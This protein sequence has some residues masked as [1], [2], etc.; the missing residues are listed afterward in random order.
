MGVMFTLSDNEFPL[1]KMLHL[2]TK[3]LVAMRNA[4]DGV[5]RKIFI[6]GVVLFSIGCASDPVPTYLPPEHPANPDALEAVYTKAPNPFPNKMSMH[7]IKSTDAPS[8]SPGMHM[9]SHS[10]AM[11][12]GQSNPEKSTETKTEKSD[13]DH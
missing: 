5:Y 3:R 1:I 2:L 9:D 10:D 11:K 7:E 12:P 13:H 4:I 6:F 8:M